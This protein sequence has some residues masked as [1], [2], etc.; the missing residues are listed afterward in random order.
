MWL[1]RGASGYPGNDPTLNLSATRVPTLV[2]RGEHDPFFSRSEALA[3]C[4]QNPA[5]F[6]LFQIDNVSHNAH[7]AAPQIF[8]DKI[9]AFLKQHLSSSLLQ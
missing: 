7:E 8:L 9:N 5:V 6:S 2:V 3:L 1:Y 4:A